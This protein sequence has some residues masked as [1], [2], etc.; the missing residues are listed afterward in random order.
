M[1][2]ILEIGDIMR[3]I[4]IRK[5]TALADGEVIV[6]SPSEKRIMLPFEAKIRIGAI[7]KELDLSDKVLLRFVEDLTILL[8]RKGIIK[9]NEIPTHVIEK[10]IQRNVLRR[11]LKELQS[12]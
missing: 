3:K 5:K 11:E 6:H 1:H 9:K 12:L 8:V 7:L 2:S 4:T 10:T